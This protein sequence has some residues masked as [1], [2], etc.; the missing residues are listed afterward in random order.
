LFVLGGGGMWIALIF[1]TRMII[2]TG[3]RLMTDTNCCISRG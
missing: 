3:N 1:G 2:F